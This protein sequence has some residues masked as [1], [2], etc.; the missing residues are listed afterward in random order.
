MIY[1]P[2]QI[3]LFRM[4]AQMNSYYFQIIIHIGNG[5]WFVL[6]SY[7]C[8]FITSIHL[9]ISH[10]KKTINLNFKES[11]NHSVYYVNDLQTE[12]ILFLYII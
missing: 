9:T 2:C 1:S 8:F 7:Y 12:G 11:T 6:V 5:V 3:Y 4:M 10:R